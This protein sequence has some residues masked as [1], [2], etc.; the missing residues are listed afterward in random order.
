MRN[1]KLFAVSLV[2]LFLFV[3]HANAHNIV[4]TAKAAG[5]FETLLTAAKKAGLVGAL[6]HKKPITLF[7]PTDAA[8][9][10]LPKGTVEK[11]LKPKNR[12]KLKKILLYHVIP[13]KVKAKDVPI[14]PKKVKT[15]SGKKVRVD[16]DFGKVEVNR[17]DVIKADIKASNG[18]I[19]VID[20]VLIPKKRKKK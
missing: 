7:A 12:K 11:L 20:E 13:G 1:L 10:K 6:S 19:H 17:V 2:T 18:I 16:R 9:A 8:F 4:E 5:K 15:L 14:F 3:G